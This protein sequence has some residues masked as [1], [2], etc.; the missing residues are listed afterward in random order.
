MATRQAQRLARIALAPSIGALSMLAFVPLALVFYFAFLRYN[1]QDPDKIFWF[2]WNNFYY[3][4]KDPYFVKNLI[5]TLLL[6]FG[7]IVTTVIGGIALAILFDQPFWGRGFARVLMIS[8][9]LHSTY[10]VVDGVEEPDHASPIR[11]VCR[12]SK[13]VRHCATISLVR[14]GAVVF[15]RLDRGVAVVA[16]CRTHPAHSPAI[17]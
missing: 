7:V 5:N 3:F 8:P 15:S 11:V 1:L 9:L 12:D 6:V 10:R 2:G 13:M 16:L 4:L 14:A 17:T